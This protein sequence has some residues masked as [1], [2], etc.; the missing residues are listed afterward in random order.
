V[1]IGR[2]HYLDHGSEVR[3]IPNEG[4]LYGMFMSKS[5]AYRHESEVRAIFADIVGGW[6]GTAAPGHLVPV[7]IQAMVNTVTVSPLAPRWFEQLVMAT[8]SHFGFELSVRKS[9]ATM[10]PIY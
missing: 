8:C 2:V 7:D 3:T 6:S 5:V 4:N 10:E 9:I 1:F